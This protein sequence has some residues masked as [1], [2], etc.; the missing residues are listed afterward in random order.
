MPG[1]REWLAQ[2]E[3][4]NNMTKAQV[5]HANDGWAP[6]GQIVAGTRDSQTGDLDAGSG[7]ATLATNIG[8]LF[9]LTCGVVVVA[10]LYFGRE[11]LLPITLAV[12]LSFILSPVVNF[13]Q[14]LRIRRVPAVVFTVLAALGF[15]G[16]VATLIWTQAAVLSVHAPQYASAIESKVTA[17]QGVATSRMDALT[18]ALGE[19]RKPRPL[20]R[21]T[22]GTAA[23]RLAPTASTPRA[24]VPVE[25]APAKTTP[26]SVAKAIVEPLVKP[27]GTTFIVLMVA[28]FVLMQKD[29][30]RDRFIRLFGSTDLHRTTMAL[31][32][33]GARLSRY[34]IAQLAVNTG[35][36]IVIGA[37][38]WLIDIP[39]PV[40]WGVLAAVL[41]FVP[42]IGAILAA[43]VPVALGA[44]IDPGWT[45]ALLVAA[46]FV[47]VESLIGYVVEPILYGH[48]TGLSPVSVIIAAIFWTWIWGP[49][50]LVLSTPLTL[51]LV[52]LG[53]HV[54][55]L[56]F[57][58]VLLGDRPA[59]TPVE[60]LYQRIL[61][62]NPDE[63]L[64]Q[65][66][67]LLVDY[68]LP[69]YYDA[70]MLGA[71]RLAAADEAAG[72]LSPADLHRIRRSVTAVLEE[73]QLIVGARK[74]ADADRPVPAKISLACV[75]GAGPFDQIVATMCAQALREHGYD[76]RLVAQ[77]EA[78]REAIAGLDLSDVDTILICYLELVGSPAQL[79]FLV[80]RLRQRAPQARLVAGLWSEGGGVPGEDVHE[81]I[82]AD[83]HAASISAAIE[84]IGRASRA[85]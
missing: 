82:G 49:A 44:A 84:V 42:Y 23:A 51:C 41:R 13:L 68:S 34:F 80:R 78:T 29:D 30:L 8:R 43:V 39:S 47:V 27:L 12:M 5:G 77:A 70:V 11:V 79:R 63:A 20:A 52:V 7:P 9:G 28:I 2:G 45:T 37:G 73:L 1:G 53:R 65:A 71:M 66:E 81:L 32:D 55:A 54:K 17:L 59:L 60:E 18:R 31:N 48:S 35:F 69:Q 85:A 76:P 26:V 75:A 22:Q 62:N 25:I 4:G 72:S 50:G 64:A 61:A 6:V 46:S 36:G 57:F 56:E 83:D 21:P 15:I 3:R 40:L 16:A 38:L 33:A 24:P 74:S 58:D 14:R 10:A 67:T 19:G